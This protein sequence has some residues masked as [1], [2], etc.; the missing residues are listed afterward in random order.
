MDLDALDELAKQRLALAELSLVEQRR[1][2][3]HRIGIRGYRRLLGQVPSDRAF[4]FP[5]VLLQ[6]GALQL[7]F[8]ESPLDG[9]AELVLP[10]SNPDR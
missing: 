9:R 3:D 2:R 4:E 1:Q 5:P 6:L 10:D 7:Q 8:L